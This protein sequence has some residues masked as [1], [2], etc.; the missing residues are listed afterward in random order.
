MSD[1]KLAQAAAHRVAPAE[2]ARRK[3]LGRAPVMYQVRTLIIDT[4]QYFN[5]KW[6]LLVSIRG[7]VFLGHMLGTQ[8]AAH[9]VAPAE[10]SGARHS[11]ERPSCTMCA[12]S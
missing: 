6:Y 8:A 3:A 5:L 11:A 10:A 12:C 1:S 2:A 9:T 4:V 7:V